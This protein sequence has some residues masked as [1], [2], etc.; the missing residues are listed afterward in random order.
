[1][2]A[3]GGTVTLDS[4]MSGGELVTLWLDMPIERL[5]GFS[6]GAATLLASDLNA[7]LVRLTRIAQML[8]RDVRRA[9][10]LPVDDPQ[11]GQD[12]ELPDQ[13]DRAGKFLAFDASG[14][15]TPASG[16]GT[17]SSLR[18]DLASSGAG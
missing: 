7:E 17:D 2:D 13:T 4:A 8:R 5:T 10:H 15:P 11:S 12:M 6:T 3:G 1:G 14:N 9:L 16:T 18:D